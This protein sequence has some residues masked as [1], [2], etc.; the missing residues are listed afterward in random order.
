[1]RY[2]VVV[3]SMRHQKS[4]SLLV[5]EAAQLSRETWR[6]GDKVT[7]LTSKEEKCLCPVWEYFGFSPDDKGEP[8][9]SA[10]YWSE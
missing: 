10:D 6:L 1:M 2:R 3:R 8:A 7:E 5:D 4:V 9:N